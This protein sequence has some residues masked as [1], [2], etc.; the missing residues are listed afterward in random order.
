ML[1]LGAAAY[2]IPSIFMVSEMTLRTEMH[3]ARLASDSLPIAINCDCSLQSLN[4]HL[5]TFKIGESQSLLS[6]CTNDVRRRI[7]ASETLGDLCQF[8]SFFRYYGWLVLLFSF[9]LPTLLPHLVL[10]D[11]IL[12][13]FML[14]FLRLTL[15]FH[16]TWSVN[17]F[18][19]YVGYKPFDRNMKPTEVPW[20]SLVAVGEG[21]HN[22]HHTFPHDYNCSELGW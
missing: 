5:I 17:S 22:Y 7:E 11:P 19:H 9:G 14:C 18:A 20:V 6:H 4:A 1:P 2:Q 12:A 10:G 8:F 21:W 16:F 13:L 15:S 3:R